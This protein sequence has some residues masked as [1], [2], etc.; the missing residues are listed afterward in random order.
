M[1]A[2][3]HPL[4]DFN[5]GSLQLVL[6]AVASVAGAAYGAMRWADSIASGVAATSGEVMLAALPLLIGVQLLLGALNFDVQNIPRDPLVRHGEPL[7][8]PAG[9]A[10]ARLEVEAPAPSPLAPTGSA[11]QPPEAD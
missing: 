1:G 11:G 9:L 10:A 8:A 7:G 2:S 6:G 3:V 5:A 4:R